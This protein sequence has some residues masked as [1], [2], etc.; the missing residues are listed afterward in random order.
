MKT[1]KTHEEALALA[2]LWMV[3]MSDDPLHLKGQARNQWYTTFGLLTDFLNELYFQKPVAVEDVAGQLAEQ[4]PPVAEEP[5]KKASD[6]GYKFV[7]W[8]LALLKE[9][10]AP[11]LDVTDSMRNR[12]ADTYDKMIR[13]DKRTKEQIVA[14]CKW[15][16]ND[17]FWRQ[18]FLSPN[19]LRERK[20]DVMW[21]DLFL[22]RVGPGHGG[23]MPVG[24]D[25]Y[26]EP[27]GWRGKAASM[28][29]DMQMPDKWSDLSSTIRNALLQK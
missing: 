18:N 4:T 11:K 27:E 26:K 10:E 25:I 29:P 24:L 13:I 17:S 8:F 22:T 28:W 21:F 1:T 2:R 16:R 9:T 23:T 20:D 12:W 7:D 5:G 6:E 19:R 3:N 15:A 14:V